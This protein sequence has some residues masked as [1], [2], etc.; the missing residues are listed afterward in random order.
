MKNETYSEIHFAI[1]D[2]LEARKS[3]PESYTDDRIIVMAIS[4][5]AVAQPDAP[6]R[7]V[8]QAVRT[9]L[10]RQLAAGVQ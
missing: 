7:D 4:V 8:Y 2:M 5:A 3:Y 6:V 1:K 10:V 9:E